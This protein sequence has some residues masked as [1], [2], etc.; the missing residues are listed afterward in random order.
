MVWNVD[1]FVKSLNIPGFQVFV[2]SIDIPKVGD[3]TGVD[4]QKRQKFIDGLVSWVQLKN[5]HLP[6]IAWEVSDMQYGVVV[7]TQDKHPELKKIVVEF[8]NDQISYMLTHG[9]FAEFAYDKYF[10]VDA[11]VM[12]KQDTPDVSEVGKALYEAA[13]NTV[14]KEP[15]PDAS[16][17]QLRTP[18]FPARL[19]SLVASM[20][21]PNVNGLV[22]WD[23][24]MIP[25]DMVLRHA[26]SYLR[27]VVKYFA[28]EDPDVRYK[29]LDLKAYP[30]NES[31]PAEKVPCTREEATHVVIGI[32]KPGHVFEFILDVA[33]MVRASRSRQ[34]NP[35]DFEKEFWL[36]IPFNWADEQIVESEGLDTHFT[37]AIENMDAKEKVELEFH[38]FQEKLSQ[39]MAT[40]LY[41]ATDGNLPQRND[42]FIPLR[43]VHGLL[44][45]FMDWLKYNFSNIIRYDVCEWDMNV[46]LSDTTTATLEVTDRVSFRRFIVTYNY[47]NFFKGHIAAGLDWHPEARTFW[48]LPS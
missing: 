35:A 23:S 14:R 5:L 41:R 42:G 15:S 31:N 16:V 17:E 29:W 13:P 20:Q 6:E 10:W 2:E 22:G 48:R 1:V 27:G 40:T 36:P 33:A 47:D 21:V 25:R 3:F 18:P 4:Y 19:M 9:T 39:L 46:Y 24:A 38:H 45:D 43:A 34:L 7:R 30:A 28:L 11:D 32:E 12:P 8:V 26:H 37:R 44:N